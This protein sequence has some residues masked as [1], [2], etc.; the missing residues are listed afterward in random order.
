MKTLRLLFAN[1]LVLV[2]LTRSAL[3]KNDTIR[4]ETIIPPAEKK[5]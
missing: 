4:I 2:I 1:L 5:K 3:L